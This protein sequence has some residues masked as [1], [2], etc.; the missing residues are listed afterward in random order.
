MD[1]T[2][3]TFNSQPGFNFNSPKVGKENKRALHNAFWGFL[4]WL[5]AKIKENKVFHLL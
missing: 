2:L 4:K 1:L 5:V 3:F